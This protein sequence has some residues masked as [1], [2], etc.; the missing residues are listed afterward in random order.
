[1]QAFYILLF[2]FWLLYHLFELSIAVSLTMLDWVFTSYTADGVLIFSIV[3]YFRHFGGISSL[4]AP[5]IAD[6]LFVSFDITYI[7]FMKGKLAYELLILHYI[8]LI[9]FTARYFRHVSYFISIG[10]AIVMRGL[11]LR[12]V[13]LL[14]AMPPLHA[15]RRLLR[16]HWA[17]HAWCRWPLLR[18]V[19]ASL[20]PHAPQQVAAA[21]AT[22]EDDIYYAKVLALSESFDI[23]SLIYAIIM[24]AILP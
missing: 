12:C 8:L 18:C 10:D 19:I 11:D 3:A 7:D 20:P 23:S 14:E 5:R 22:A 2:A 1:M 6:M 15:C 16:G 21:A 9:S 4:C 13:H 24:L 17:Y